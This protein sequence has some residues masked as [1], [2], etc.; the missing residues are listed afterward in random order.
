MIEILKCL[1]GLFPPIRNGIFMLK[2]MPCALRNSKDLESQL[3]TR[4][5]NLQSTTITSTTTWENKKV[6][7]FLVSF[8]Q[9]IK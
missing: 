2:N 9:D 5:Y 3:E 6:P 7:T 8:S 4:K 1:K